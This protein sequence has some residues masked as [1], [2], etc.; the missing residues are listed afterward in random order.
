M[1]NL[2]RSRRAEE[3]RPGISLAAE[4]GFMP[5]IAFYNRTGGKPQVAPGP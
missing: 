4:I 3:N 5:L 1:S 2:N